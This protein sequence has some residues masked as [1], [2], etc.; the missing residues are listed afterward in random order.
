MTRLL[1][2]VEIAMLV[3]LTTS[4]DKWLDVESVK[5]A[6][7]EDMFSNTKGFYSVVNGL[8]FEMGQSNLYGQNLTW[9]AVDAWA[10]VYKLDASVSNHEGYIALQNLDY[11]VS[12][13]EGYASSIW[14]YGFKI[15]ARTN[16]LIQNIEKK[17]SLFFLNLAMEKDLLMGEAKAIRAVMH[18]DLLR[19]F[20]QAPELDREGAY[21]PWIGT[22]PSRINP[23]VPTQ[24]VLTNIITDL[25]ESKN[26]L[27]VY[28]T[29]KT[30][31]Q[32]AFT[33]ENRFNEKSI[34]AIGKFYACRGSH[35]NYLAVTGMLARAYLW[36]GD[37]DNALIQAAELVK[38]VTD[39]RLVFAS[40]TTILDNPT[41]LTDVLFALYQKDLVDNYA[42]FCDFTSTSAFYIEDPALFSEISTDKR[43]GL[44][45]TKNV[46]TRY[47]E[48]KNADKEGFI[49]M[50]RLSEVFYIAGECY[51]K[52]GDMTAAVGV[53]NTV[54][55]ARGI[56]AKLPASI[57]KTAYMEELI[58]DARKDLCGE[59]Q[60]LF[61]YKRLNVPIYYSKGGR[62]IH[63]GK[64]VMP[65]PTSESAI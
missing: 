17:D 33:F 28:D 30:N 18:L 41:M 31:Q 46:L 49:P 32:W 45:G 19:V 27:A 2:I 56:S 57:E 35:L 1:H 59:G 55:A 62:F 34:P 26:L 24:T 25:K 48:K 16:N 3:L 39:K 11:S 29:L 53:L 43:V 42:S 61:M 15:I 13:A 44:L 36:A 12:K 50:L 51:A 47:M 58:K 64:L 7:E 63:N 5:E 4:C 38:L 8:Y 21:I 52:K 37:L 40:G 10:R 54:R 23:P 65:K 22:Y 9:G 14:E 20:A 60:L 6:P